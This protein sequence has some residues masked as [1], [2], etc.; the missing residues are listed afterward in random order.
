MTWRSGIKKM[1]KIT[2]PVIERREKTNAKNF[3][4]IRNLVV[5]VTENKMK[6]GVPLMKMV[7]NL[8]ENWKRE[9]QWFEEY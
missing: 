1:H 7:S 9:R 5:Q 6:K 3:S 4:E 2:I 8:P